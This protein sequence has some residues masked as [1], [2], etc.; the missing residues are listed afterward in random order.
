[1]LF[2]SRLFIPASTTELAPIRVRIPACEGI[3]TRVVFR[4]RW[5]SANLCGARI[6]YSEY[7]V[8]PRS[9]AQ[10]FISNV[11][12]YDFEENLRISDHPHFFILEGYNTD[13]TF[14][15]AVEATINILRFGDG[16]KLSEFMTFLET[17][18][19]G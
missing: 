10:W 11:Q 18:G 8:W 15:H 17:G 2:T 4:W 16:G 7:Q 9:K 5:G 3:V 13:D 1:M 14:P 6:L 12:D 19:D